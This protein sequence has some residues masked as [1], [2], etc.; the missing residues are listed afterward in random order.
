M[1]MQMEKCA[2]M[3][4]SINQAWDNG[5]DRERYE[6]IHSLFDEIVVDLDTRQITNARLKVWAEEFLVVR[7]SL[8]EMEK[9]ENQ[10]ENG[11]GSAFQDQD[12]AMPP[13]GLRG[14]IRSKYIQCIRCDCL[15][16]KPAVSAAFAA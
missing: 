12:T 5:T 1:Y 7:A 8:Y 4:E 14:Q 13:W 6:M 11:A 3:V 16:L 10:A 15:P 2:V 9:Q